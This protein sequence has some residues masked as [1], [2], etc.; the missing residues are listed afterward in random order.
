MP[1]VQDVMPTAQNV[2]PTA[3]D[4][5]NFFLNIAADTSDDPITNLKLQKLTYYAQ[6]YHL[7][8]FQEPLFDQPIEA[9]THGPV[10][11]ELYRSY[12]HYGRAP[13]PSPVDFD[14]TEHFS[15]EQLELLDDIYSVFGQYSAWKLRNMTHEETPWLSHE[16]D[17]SVIPQTELREFF[18]DFVVIDEAEDGEEN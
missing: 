15:P 14:A 5:A 6:G 1:T 16:E 9:W 7:A 2:M 17:A 4:V 18:A 12:S 8:L 10:V 3:Q 11:P 13:I